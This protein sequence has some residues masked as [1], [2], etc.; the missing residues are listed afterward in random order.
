MSAQKKSIVLSFE[1]PTFSKKRK[2]ED[3]SNNSTV[4]D[5]DDGKDSKRPKL[6]ALPL[7]ALSQDV[8]LLIAS[9]VGPQEKYGL[10]F[11]C[12]TIRNA[13]LSGASS[14]LDGI[15]NGVED[16]VKLHEKHAS[17]L[18]LAKNFWVFDAIN[19]A[20]K[21][22]TV[23]TPN[24]S[25]CCSKFDDA[26]VLH[27]FFSR[28]TGFPADAIPVYHYLFKQLPDML[29]SDVLA[30]CQAKGFV[31]EEMKRALDV[32]LA[33]CQY[34][35]SKFDIAFK[36]TSHF[37]TIDK[38]TPTVPTVYG[39]EIP[40]IFEKGGNA[41][42][43]IPYERRMWL[44][45]NH[46]GRASTGQPQFDDRRI[47]M[48]IP[49][50][51]F[52]CELY[53]RLRCSSG[54]KHTTFHRMVAL[55]AKIEDLS[56]GGE[57]SKLVLYLHH[58][59]YNNIGTVHNV[60]RHR[61][62]TTTGGHYFTAMEESV[63]GRC[64]QIHK[65][66][67]EK[68]NVCLWDL[69][70]SICAFFVDRNINGKG[71]NGWSTSSMIKETMFTK[72]PLSGTRVSGSRSVTY[73]GTSIIC[74]VEDSTWVAYPVAKCSGNIWSL[75]CMLE[76]VGRV[77]CEMYARIMAQNAGPLFEPQVSRKRIRVP[78][79]EVDEIVK[80]NPE[81]ILLGSGEFAKFMMA[82][83][84]LLLDMIE[85]TNV[86]LLVDTRFNSI[87]TNGTPLDRDLKIPR[88]N[89]FRQDIKDTEVP[90]SSV[91]DRIYAGIINMRWAWQFYD[92]PSLWAFAEEYNIAQHP[93]ASSA[94]CNISVGVLGN[95]IP[96]VDA[97]GLAGL[98]EHLRNGYRIVNK[99]IRN[100]AY[101]TC[102][103]TLFDIKIE[104]KEKASFLTEAPIEM[105][106][107]VKLR[108]SDMIHLPAVRS[109]S[110]LKE[111]YEMEYEKMSKVRE[112]C[113]THPHHRELPMK[114]FSSGFH[115]CLSYAALQ[116][117]GVEVLDFVYQEIT[118]NLVLSQER[119]KREI[120][121]DVIIILY[122]TKQEEQ[123]KWAI[124]KLKEY[125]KNGGYGSS[126]SKM[127]AFFQANPLT[128]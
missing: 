121:E 63:L 67:M 45:S 86:D 108:L 68:C 127:L 18:G 44:G 102:S 4:M 71:A 12:K 32:L 59:V 13:L 38:G 20:Y 128:L 69:F 112:L 39:A 60:W 70:P 66:A 110:F 83:S 8:L 15:A 76:S 2:R 90:L 111:L 122:A 126:P 16:L 99:I 97:T 26:Y 33:T 123:L 14:M 27:M 74:D 114:L 6:C 65:R 73:G 61:L 35:T 58:Y 31:D 43:M 17:K 42:F 50:I 30:Y 87:G 29:Q 64:M 11:T 48:W 51:D 82:S 49:V 36:T 1:K 75:V 34:A 103:P 25:G 56:T 79:G 57:I 46:F 84:G 92:T 98:F 96:F 113:D 105:L 91:R 109:K 72:F 80:M 37:V 93:R 55:L 3:N 106:R 125:E 22:D 7:S 19:T 41:F 28:A 21:E 116:F 101:Q 115:W 23:I 40:Y 54:T 53:E 118:H 81:N 100:A 47:V 88:S 124:E 52:L 94:L 77:K 10:D 89:P 95:I 24:D 104:V 85:Y 78:V 9:F 5:N 119:A 120:L 117:R 62:P 107:F